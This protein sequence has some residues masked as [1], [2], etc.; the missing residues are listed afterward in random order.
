LVTREILFVFIF[1]LHFSFSSPFYLGFSYPYSVE[2]WLTRLFLFLFLSFLTSPTLLVR[3][4]YW[5]IGYFLFFTL[6]LSLS[7]LFL[8]FFLP[9]FFFSYFCFSFLF[10]FVNTL[11][12]F[13]ILL[14]RWFSSRKRAHRVKDAF[15]S[16][17]SHREVF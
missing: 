13:N 7:I 4:Y 15:S 6:S 8:I 3:V 14:D 10:C 12:W 9:L 2:G 11:E 5:C 1:F 17:A 16:P